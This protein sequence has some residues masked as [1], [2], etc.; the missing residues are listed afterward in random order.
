[1]LLGE[2]PHSRTRPDVLPPP[3]AAEHGPTGDE[4]TRQIGAGGPHQVGGGGLVAPG[5][6]DD[7]VQ[8]VAAERLLEIHGHEVAQEHGRRPYEGL[9]DGRC[10]ELEG[11]TA[12]LPHPPLDV[13]GN[14]T[15]MDVAGCELRPALSD[16]DHRP[17]AERVVRQPLAAQPRA[18]QYPV[19][20]RRLEPSCAAQPSHVKTG[21]CCACAWIRASL[22][23]RA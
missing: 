15:Q 1:M 9:A 23:A 22:R 16:A 3:L 19:L 5:Q 4:Q 13:V 14:F 8:W 6:Q 11:H 7:P 12:G 20:A 21:R 2:P 17:A 10:G 18:V